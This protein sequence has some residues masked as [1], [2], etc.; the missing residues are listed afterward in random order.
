MPFKS[1]AQRRYMHAKHPRMAKEWEAHTPKGKKL[2]E[3]VAEK[4]ASVAKL[5][6]LV[7]TAKTARDMPHFTDQDRPEKVKEIYRALKR[8]HPEMPAEEKARI[9]ARQ[10]KPGKQHQ[11][12]PYK[13]PIKNK[14]ASLTPSRIALGLMA[15]A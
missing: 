9:A 5:A 8:D 7:M 13:G 12:P 3:H 4:E 1:E 6:L 10:G 11:G 14:E 2:P 15:G